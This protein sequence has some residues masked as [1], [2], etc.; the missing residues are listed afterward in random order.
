VLRSH[1]RE[2]QKVAAFGRW[3]FIEGEYQYKIKIWEHLVWL[4]KTGWLLKKGDH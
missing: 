2:A 3:L 1:W 4:L